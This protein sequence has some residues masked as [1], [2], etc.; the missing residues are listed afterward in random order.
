MRHIILLTFLLTQSTILMAADSTVTTETALNAKLLENGVTSQANKTDT[1]IKIL[2]NGGSA[3][4]KASSTNLTDQD[5]QLS[6]NYVHQGLAN[7]ILTEKCVGEMV[8]GCAG[9]EVDHKTMGMSPILIKV[10]A[11]AYATV[12]L[13]GDFLPLSPPKATAKVDAK[14]TPDAADTTKTPDAAKDATDTKSKKVEDYC[15]YIPAG[16]ESVAKFAQ[17]ATVQSMSVSAGGET[18]QK[19]A[20]LK[21]AKSHDGRAQQAQIQAVGWFGGA[22]C[23]AYKAASGSVAVDTNLVV[24][25]GAATLLGTFYQ[26]EVGANK[27]YAKK[28]RDIA[29]SLPGKGDC[30]PVTEN[31]CYCAQPETA[32]DPTYCKAQIAQKAAGALAFTRVACTDSNLKLDANCACEKTNSCFDKYLE[33]Q[34]AVDLQLGTGYANSPFKSVASLARGRLEGGSLSDSAYAGT[35]AIAKKA[36]DQFSSKLPANNNPLTREQKDIADAI[37][38]KG[39]PANVARLMAQN[40]P[41]KSALDS[42]SAKMGSIGST[43]ELASYSGKNNSVNFSG[44]DGLG[45][46]GKKSDK[47]SD[48]FLSKFAAAGKGNGSSNQKVVEFAQKA[49]AQAAQITKTNDR[50]IFEIISNRY[51]TSGRRLLEIDSTK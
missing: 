6:E 45:V 48:D 1:S 8:Q 32:N 31:D 7:R 46:N 35:S 19:D 15:K 25:L 14:A 47:K 50:P 51:Q 42:A 41:S 39:I 18:S 11:Q 30:N 29:D 13:V 9:N 16:T 26:Q 17:Q 40:S 24:K 20:L 12:G 37:A 5:K 27:E 38:S 43:Y 44:G 36:L 22:A 3:T 49:Q 23:Y 21:A 34:G 28:T 4:A 10:A 33:N 2:S